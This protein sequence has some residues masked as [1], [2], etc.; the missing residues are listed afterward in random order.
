MFHSCVLYNLDLFTR[1]GFVPL[2][3]SSVCTHAQSLNNY[4]IPSARLCLRYDCVLYKCIQLWNSLDES[5]KNCVCIKKC[6]YA[7]HVYY[8]V[9]MV[10]VV[11]VYV[12]S[13]KF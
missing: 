7:F 12:L 3:H 10:S 6:M 2:F 5:V 1:N 11:Y 4:F 8:L 13:V 9:P